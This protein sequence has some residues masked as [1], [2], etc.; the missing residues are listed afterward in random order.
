MFGIAQESDEWDAKASPVHLRSAEAILAGCLKNGGVY[1]KL[2]Q[3]LISFNHILPK[4]YLKTLAVLQDRALP[5]GKQEVSSDLLL[6]LKR[7]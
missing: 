1:I 7:V 3:G 2:G 6:R 4:E 5:R